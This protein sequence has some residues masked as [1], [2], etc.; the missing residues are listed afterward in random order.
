MQE[1]DLV[2]VMM[3]G[4]GSALMGFSVDDSVLE[5]A[6]EQLKDETDFIQIVQVG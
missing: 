4:S 6:Y 5:Y 2:R 3:T 1:Y